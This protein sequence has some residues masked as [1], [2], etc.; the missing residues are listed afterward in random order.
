MSMSFTYEILIEH[1][2]LSFDGVGNAPFNEIREQQEEGDDDEGED[3]KEEEKEEE[4][5][6]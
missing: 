1:L 4:K 5:E 2:K 6:R 3:E